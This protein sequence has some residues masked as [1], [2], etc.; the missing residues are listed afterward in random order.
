MLHPVYKLPLKFVVRL[1]L[2]K[3]GGGGA[4]LWDTTVLVLIHEHS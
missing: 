1:R 3:G 4:Y 2:Q